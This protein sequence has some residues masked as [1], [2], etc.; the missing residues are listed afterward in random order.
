MGQFFKDQTGQF[1]MM[2]LGQF[3]VILAILLVFLAANAAIVIN[4]I[5]KGDA[6]TIADFQPQMVWMIGIVIAG[7]VAQGAFVEKSGDTIEQPKA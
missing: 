3:M 2:R 1:S 7:K 6:V 4:A 5:K